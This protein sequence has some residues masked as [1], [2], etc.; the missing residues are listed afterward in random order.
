LCRDE[1]AGKY[2]NGQLDSAT[3][4]EFEVH[5]LQCAPC[6][7]HVEALQALR[8]ELSESGSRIRAYPPTTKP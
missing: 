5:I 8:Q 7:Q 3:R 1:F 2:L 6:L 4:D